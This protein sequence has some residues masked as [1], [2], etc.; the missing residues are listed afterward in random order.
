MVGVLE[1]TCHH[2]D[3]S[4]L[5]IKVDTRN[6]QRSPTYECLLCNV[7]MNPDEYKDVIRTIKEKKEEDTLK[8]WRTPKG[9]EHTLE[10]CV[11]PED[12]FVHEGE[13]Q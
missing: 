2:I 8:F 5:Q 4:G 1:M 13:E 3:W 9:K 10:E 7:V 12:C 6:G 11:K